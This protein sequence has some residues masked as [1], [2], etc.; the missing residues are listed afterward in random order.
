MHDI[1]ML[2]IMEQ[3]GDKNKL[4]TSFLRGLSSFQ[5]IALLNTRKVIREIIVFT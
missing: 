1:Q 5:M 4:L 2:E 3:Y